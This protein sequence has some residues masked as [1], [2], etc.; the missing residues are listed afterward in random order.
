MFLYRHSD[1]T[2]IVATDVAISHALIESLNITGWK[3]AS[4]AEAAI[5]RLMQ[6]SDVIAFV[7]AAYL[8]IRLEG[9]RD[10]CI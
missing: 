4:T 3:P 5:G 10:K 1:P 8:F 6:T 9:D 7:I 2:W